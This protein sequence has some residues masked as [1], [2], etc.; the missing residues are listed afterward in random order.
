[1]TRGELERTHGHLVVV[2]SRYHDQLSIAIEAYEPGADHSV[3]RLRDI[4][5][6]ALADFGLDGQVES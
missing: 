5:L 2:A 3:E 1:V 6:R 4:A